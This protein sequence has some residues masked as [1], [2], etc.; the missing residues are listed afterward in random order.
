[1]SLYDLFGIGI[2]GN[3]GFDGLFAAFYDDQDHDRDHDH[4]Q[5]DGDHDHQDITDRR[6]AALS[7]K[8]RNRRNMLYFPA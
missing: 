8:A 1:M 5:Y 3:D 7:D 6:C 4:S 2:V